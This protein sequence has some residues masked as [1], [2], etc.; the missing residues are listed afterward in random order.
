MKFLGVLLGVGLVFFLLIN[1]KKNQLD[2]DII[3]IW[4]WEDLHV[5]ARLVILG[6]FVIE[7]LVAVIPVLTEEVVR[8][9]GMKDI[10]AF[11]RMVGL[12]QIVK[13]M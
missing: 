13:Q 11:A 9:L 12:E 6:S 4:S 5:P 10:N 3:V 1:H 2:F 8:L 7:D